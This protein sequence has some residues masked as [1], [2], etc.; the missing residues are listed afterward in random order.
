MSPD[1]IATD[2]E[3]CR[4]VADWPTPKCLKEVRAFIG[5]ASYYRRFVLGFSTVAKPLH[6]LTKKGEKFIWDDRCQTAF[7]EL[8]RRL[9]SPPILAMPRDQGVL[10]L[11]TD[12]SDGSIG[13]VLSQ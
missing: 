8:K 2:P 10:Y 1:G 4:A 3:K 13:A 11:D 5:L 12:A 7:E 9:V 6:N